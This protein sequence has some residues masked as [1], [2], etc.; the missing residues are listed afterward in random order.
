MRLRHLCTLGALLLG[1]SLVSAG[2]PS[3]HPLAKAKAG[4]WVFH[5]STGSSGDADNPSFTYKWIDKVEKTEVRLMIQP[6][7]EDGKLG[8]SAPTLMTV[9]L[10]K[11]PD[12]EEASTATAEE[13][14]VVKGKPLKCKRIDFVTQ[15]T[16]HGKVTTSRWVSDEVPIYGTV[17]MITFDKDKKEIARTDLL[18]FGE[19]GGA[20]K[21]LAPADDHPTKKN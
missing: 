9:N 17:R 14:L 15:D 8:L 1:M 13:E 7:T 6:V 16:R 4:Q 21:P 2:E 11:P 3:T 18:D 20:E 12:K 5:R 10:D 19:T